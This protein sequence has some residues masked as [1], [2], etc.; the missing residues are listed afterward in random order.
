MKKTFLSNIVLVA[1]FLLNGGVW[2]NAQTPIDSVD[3]P[4]VGSLLG[5]GVVYHVDEVTRKVLVVALTESPT[6]AKNFYR[7]WGEGGHLITGASYGKNGLKNTKAIIAGQ[8]IIQDIDACRD[9]TVGKGT[10]SKYSCTGFKLP[11]D[12]ARRAAH[13]CTELGQEWFLPSREQLKKMYNAKS[14]VNAVLATTQGATLLGDGFYWSSTQSGAH[15]A[16]YVFFDN[17]ETNASLKTNSG[18]VRP[19][20]EY[21]YS[22]NP[23]EEVEEEEV[24][25]G[26]QP[27]T[28]EDDGGGGDDGGGDDGGD[29]GDDGG[30]DTTAA[31]K[32]SLKASLYPVPITADM[33][34]VAGVEGRLKVEVYNSSGVLL[35]SKICHA[36]EPINLSAMPKGTLFVKLSNGGKSVTKQVVKL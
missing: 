24:P 26:E 35:M 23:G 31:E 5:G 9:N 2:A 13:W 14:A 28:G 6:N 22:S 33:L 8:V 10:E 17:G 32:S 27:S 16:W 36:G 1:F 20:R 25:I 30:G 11:A 7:T 3:L 12:T 19:I 29:G 4:Q 21:V 18:S 15:D 34:Y